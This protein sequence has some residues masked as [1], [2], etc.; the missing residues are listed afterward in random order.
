MSETQKEFYTKPPEFLSEKVTLPQYKKDLAR[1]KRCT[2]V[3][4][5]RQ[6]DVVLLSIPSSHPLKER[7]ENEIGDTVAESNDG[8]KIILDKLEEILGKDEVLEAYIAFKELE[9][10]QRLVGQ[11]VIE[12][13][14]EWDTLYLRAKS[15]GIELHE[16]VKSFKLLM[17]CNLDEMD[18]K[19]VLSEVDI[20]SE[21]GKKKLYDQMKLAIRKF[22]SAGSLQSHKSA[23]KVLFTDS[24]MSQIEEVFV[25]NG[26]TKPEEAAKRKKDVKDGNA[27]RKVKRENGY[28][29]DGNWRKCFKCV[30]ECSHDKKKCDCSCSKHHL[31]EL[32]QKG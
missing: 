21:D 14:T 15:K 16:T 6:G 29:K 19:L 2:S 3:P 22:H 17:T 1:W 9:L 18:L 13:V 8:V 25:A 5:A 7:L 30:K 10:K 27:K 12:Y 26:W 20:S 32:S 31:P 4:V 23:S 11:D 24:Q 28:D